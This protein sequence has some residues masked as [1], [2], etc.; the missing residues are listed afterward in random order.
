MGTFIHDV[1][2]ATR[3]LLHRP[4]FAAVAILTL[5]LGIG[6]NTSMFSIVNA[7]LLRPLPYPDADRLV[8]VYGTS[9]ESQRLGFT[10][11]YALDLHEQ[12]PAFERIGIF[13]HWAAT[14]AEPGEPAE[15]L[16]ALRVSWDFLPTLGVQPALGRMF[17]ADEDRPGSHVA[18]L[19]H[20]TWANQFGADPA[21]AGR[22]VRLDGQPVIIVGVM[23]EHFSAP[24][25]FGPV[26][27]LRPLGL[28][29]TDRD[30]AD[31]WLHLVA[32]MPPGASRAQAAGALDVLATRFARE[33][34][35]QN[36]HTGMHLMP[37][38]A[39]GTHETGHSFSWF[40]LA[41][42]G[43]VLLI[44]CANLANLHLVRALARTRELSVRAALGAPWSR[45]IRSLAAESFVLAAV[46]GA[47]ALIVAVW[48]NAWFASR[49][50]MPDASTL[51]IPLDG[52]VFAFAAVAA[53]VAAVISGTAPALLA[54][55][56]QLTDSL[57]QNAR[58]ATAGPVPNRIR[59][60]LVIGELALALMLLAGAGFFLSGIERFVDR[61]LGW[62]AERIVSGNIDLSGTEHVED[63]EATNLFFEQ[64]QQRAAALPGVE[65]AAIGWALPMW[66]YLSSRMIDVEG[67]ARPSD[68][69]PPVAFFNGVRPGYFEALDMRLVDGRDF[70]ERD[71]EDAPAVAVINQT[72]ARAFWPGESAV[73]KRIAETDRTGATSADWI[74]IV[75]VVNNV[76]FAIYL[77][78]PATPFQV[79]RPFAQDAWG[80]A[81]IALRA[82]ADPAALAEPL[83]RVVADLDADLAVR[84][85]S[86]V[87]NAVRR[88][89]ASIRLISRVL[90][91]FA[92]LGLLLAAI[93]IYGVIAHVVAQRTREIGVRIAL[94]AQVRDVTWLVLGAGIRLAAA[95]AVIGIV[96][97][98]AL[99][100][101]LRSVVPQIVTH[102]PWPIAVVTTA[103]VGVALFACYLPARRAARVDPM[104]TLTQ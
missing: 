4:G 33:D 46:G 102:G 60:A 74:E 98:I 97:S 16:L 44:A 100:R 104:T 39:S 92:L 83:R 2:I 82:S 66:Q 96:G 41:I 8:R 53:L 35:R 23:P 7:V 64:L 15:P 95:G 103:L 14:L 89:I 71:V 10:V 58:G 94:G 75:G 24:L 77:D 32:R 57:K 26:D 59:H 48:F 11:K 30:R 12:N 91:G 25:V 76:Q 31:R 65:A 1:R 90:G 3:A 51:R 50:Q 70:T 49:F 29:A 37:L 19:M 54:R 28:T 13:T 20:R 45:L 86:T 79:Y 34:P 55:R 72:M 63:T 43:F 22:T 38:Q 40:A 88:Y 69:A 6:L 61:G 80:Y 21:I 78:T 85:L 99:G 68:Q 81:A 56:V 101:L 18:I 47:A 9:P 73:G 62:D 52:R 84:D 87:P 5:A 17:T 42:S 67:R 27:L 93:G 36:T